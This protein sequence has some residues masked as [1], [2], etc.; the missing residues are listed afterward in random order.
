MKKKWI[1]EAHRLLTLPQ[2]G[3]SAIVPE[4]FSESWFYAVQALGYAY[5]DWKAALDFFEKAVQWQCP[6]G[7]I[8]LHVNG[9]QQPEGFLLQE[10]PYFAP[11]LWR[12]SETAPDSSQRKAALARFLPKL[13]S[14]QMFWYGQRD[15]RQEGLVAIIHPQESPQ[16]T[17]VH[18]HKSFQSGLEQPNIGEY[19]HP[20][21]PSRQVPPDK[22]CVQDPYLNALLALSN[23][24]LLR[25]GN[26]IGIDLQ[27]ILEMHEL[28]VFSMNEKLWNEEYGIFSA[29]D[30]D[31]EELIL[32]GALGSWMPWIGAVPDQ[33]RAEEM[34][35][36][37]EA[38]FHHR[39]FYLCA[40]NSIFASDAYS[41][42]PQRKT[43]HLWDNWLLFQGLQLYD[44]ADLARN[45]RRDIISICQKYGFQLQYPAERHPTQEPNYHPADA[46]PAAAILT[47]FLKGKPFLHA[48]T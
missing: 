36:A 31:A 9:F 47:A 11:I 22:F 33:N 1:E 3:A 10:R 40:S 38:N 8:P 23:I 30:L 6:D 16:P 35:V 34:R 7:G 17:A 25:L 42:I 4:G 45:L 29:Y 18:R 27:E 41:E 37:F 44:F 14:N 48:L 21:H 5:I 19:A 13:I 32:S 43:I 24:L 2:A 20:D 26:S 15:F 12:L 46:T 39:D 28:T